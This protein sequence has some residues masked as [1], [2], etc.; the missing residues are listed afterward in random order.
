[1]VETALALQTMKVKI[2]QHRVRDE[3]K[4]RQFLAKLEDLK[5]VELRVEI[6]IMEGNHVV[7]IGR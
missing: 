4:Y 1:L 5:G 6:S 7:E 3:G 2:S